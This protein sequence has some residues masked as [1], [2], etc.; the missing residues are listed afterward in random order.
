MFVI[1]FG[2]VFAFVFFD[3]GGFCVLFVF[4]FDP[5]GL[6]LSLSL[7]LYALTQKETG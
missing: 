1:V 2:F 3:K 7:Q 6:L 5:D 4:V